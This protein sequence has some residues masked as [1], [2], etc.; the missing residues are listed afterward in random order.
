M[1][2]LIV[3]VSLFIS[4]PGWAG[5]VEDFLHSYVNSYTDY[6]VSG[7]NKF[8]PQVTDHFNKPLLQ[9]PGKSEPFVAT[10]EAA[11]AKNFTGFMSR[12]R[13]AGVRKIEWEQTGYAMVGENRAISSN[14]ARMLDDKGEVLRK[15]AGLYALYRFADGWKIIM[16]Q[17]IAE[18]DVLK[19]N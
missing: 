11:V 9:V 12:I 10:D 16:I 4:I 18:D 6:L 3:L 1:R 14:V 15:S 5:E 7:D 19:L 8:V 13:D 2:N 17:S